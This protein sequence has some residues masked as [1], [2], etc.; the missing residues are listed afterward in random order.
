IDYVLGI[1]KA[2]AT[3]VGGGPFPTEL[4]DA[5]GNEIRQRGD[6][7]GATTG[8]PR[9]CGWIDLVALKRAVLISGISGLCV[10]KLDVLDGLP[11]IK[12]AIA[13]HYRGKK[14]EYAPL[15]AAGW[16]EC[17]PEYL[18]F[19]GWS[20]PTRGI[21]EF[22]RLPAAARAYLRALEELVGCPLA[23]VSTGPDRDENIVLKDPFA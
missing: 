18:E 23:M 14:T 10:T 6:E 13:Y 1:T 5:L 16:D 22:G 17:T 20:E 7:F 4:H 15:D 11:T 8:R 21:R 12:M 3:R 2:Y 19:P 9:R